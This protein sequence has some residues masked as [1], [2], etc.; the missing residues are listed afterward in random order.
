VHEDVDDIRPHYWRAAAVVS[1]L[2]HGAGLRN[3]VLH[4]MACGAPV[5]ATPTA[6]EGV[7][8][9]AA[10]AAWTADTTAGLADAIVAVLDDP[11]RVTRAATATAALAHLRTPAV[12]ARVEAWLRRA[13][14]DAQAPSAPSS[15]SSSPP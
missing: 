7:P 5:V 11:D 3:K 8:P 10:A 15:S 14:D 4:A 12:V 6:L 9:A 2:R 13:V 1:N